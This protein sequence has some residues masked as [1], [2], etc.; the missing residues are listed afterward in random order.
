MDFITQFDALS[1]THT[2]EY[3]SKQ[4]NNNQKKK[5]RVLQK[6]LHISCIST[7]Y[8]HFEKLGK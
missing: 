3:I 5:N 6:D 8:L 1:H 4:T 2:L 7:S